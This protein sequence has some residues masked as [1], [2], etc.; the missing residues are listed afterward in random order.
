MSAVWGSAGRTGDEGNL[1][2]GFLNVQ[3]SGVAA[4]LT[5]SCQTSCADMSGG[6]ELDVACCVFLQAQA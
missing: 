4:A 6:T 3:V 1:I 2:Q 5:L